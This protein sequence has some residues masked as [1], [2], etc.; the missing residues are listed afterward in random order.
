M[1]TQLRNATPA[2]LFEGASAVWLLDEY[3]CSWLQQAAVAMMRAKDKSHCAKPAGGLSPEFQP[4]GRR[5]SERAAEVS[6]VNAAARDS[7]A[8]AGWTGVVS[9]G[10]QRRDLPGHRDHAS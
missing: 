5:S 9:P 7:M 3:R 6:Q 8:R 2:L 4:D 1:K 10:R